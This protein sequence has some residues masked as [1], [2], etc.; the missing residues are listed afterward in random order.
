MINNYQQLLKNIHQIRIITKRSIHDCASF[1][2]LSPSEFLEFEQGTSF[3]SLPQIELL[4]VFLGVPVS[5]LFEE[6]LDDKHQLLIQDRDLHHRYQLIRQKMIQAKIT[7]GQKEKNLSLVDLHQITQ[8]PVNT[9]E[10][11]LHNAMPIPVH[12]LLLILHAL[13]KPIDQF[14]NLDIQNGQD[15][16]QS[17]NATNWQP[18]FP[19]ENH[20]KVDNGNPYILL[21]ETLDHLPKN[22]QAEILKALLSLIR[23]NW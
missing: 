11:Y 4:A 9:L 16:H 2:S 20:R 19:D 3:L 1:L 13:E 10:S 22:D 7:C 21:L 17:E 6:D 8:I 14:V 12:H 18:E 15:N 5:K 23:E